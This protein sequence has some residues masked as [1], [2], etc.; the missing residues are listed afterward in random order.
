MQAAKEARQPEEGVGTAVKRRKVTG[1]GESK[2]G[3][4]HDS[5][6]DDAGGD[7]AAD[8]HWEEFDAMPSQ[9]VDVRGACHC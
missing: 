1:A 7:L 8:G 9:G 5:D 6:S 2:D 3:H 4:M